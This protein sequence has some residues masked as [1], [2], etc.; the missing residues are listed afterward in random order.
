M[1]PVKSQ[2]QDQFTPQIL[3]TT[4]EDMDVTF[5][6][7]Y[8]SPSHQV[9]T[10]NQS[11][12]ASKGTV[13][14]VNLPIALRAATTSPANFDISVNVKAEDGKT[15]VVYLLNE[16]QASTDI[17]LL[18][19]K[20]STK[21]NTY[22]YYAV[23]APKAAAHL[24]DEER[25]FV[26]IVATEDNCVVEV[27][28]TAR[29]F[30]LIQNEAGRNITNHN[31]GVLIRSRKLQKSFVTFL[32][33]EDDL[34]GTKVTGSCYLSV[35]TGHQCAFIP[36]NV[37]SCDGILEQIPPTETW[38]F[39]FFLSPLA[40][41]LSTGYRFI[42][43]ASNTVVKHVC[44]GMEPDTFT[45]ARAGIFR[46]LLLHM[47][48]YCYVACNQPLLVAQYSLGQQ[49]GG[50]FDGFADPFLTLIV[51]VGQFNNEYSF[52][53]V[54]SVT[55]QDAAQPVVF[56]PYLNLVLTKECCQRTNILYDGRPLPSDVSLI[57]ITCDGGVV[58]GCAAQFHPSVGS[59]AHTLGHTQDSC[60]MGATLYAYEDQNSYGSL[61]GTRLDSIAGTHLPFNLPM[62]IQHTNVVHKQGT[63]MNMYRMLM[64]NHRKLCIAT[65][66]VIYCINLQVKNGIFSKLFSRLMIMQKGSSVVHSPYNISYKF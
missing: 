15:I 30:G 63:V 23:S 4:S 3:I 10:F 64:C 12:T 17:A 43:G 24:R 11:F 33:S 14:K 31:P 20:F 61:A 44:N 62:P 54:Q 65:R 51:P 66:F 42:A 29:A 32:T 46:D 58:C 6:V 19:P 26:G 37:Q 50:I 1:P 36:A 59:G 28:P 41:R 5:T 49:Y 55:D 47:P 8:E 45:L 40:K 9:F 7:S 25:S 13:T 27:T 21:T 39:N 34:T 38:G 57:D 18:Y 16:D 52:I 48:T 22:T 56:E 60:G 53:L 2:E 35:I